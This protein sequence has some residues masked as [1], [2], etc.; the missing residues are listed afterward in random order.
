MSRRPP[1]LY[2]MRHGETDWNVEWRLQGQRDIVQRGAPGQQIGILKDVADMSMRS[3]VRAG[4]NRAGV[5]CV[6][7]RDD[8]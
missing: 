2:Y 3:S 5:R 1:L 6:E 4:L 8:S 7:P